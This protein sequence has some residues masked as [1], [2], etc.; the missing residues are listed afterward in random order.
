MNSILLA[1]LLLASPVRA[2][3]PSLALPGGVEP[4]EWEQALRMAGIELA[5]PGELA[6]ITCLPEPGGWMLVAGGAADSR[7]VARVPVPGSQ[8][9]R[10]E[11]ALLAASLMQDLGLWTG[12][13]TTASGPGGDGDAAPQLSPPVDFA[14]EP[15]QESVLQPSSPPPRH[16]TPAP[17]TAEPL[18]G[19]EPLPDTVLTSE[20][21]QI[22]PGPAAEL[23]AEVPPPPPEDTPAEQPA[24]AQSDA[25]APSAAPPEQAI[26]TLW[27][28]TGSGL[29]LRAGLDPGWY[30]ALG[31]G[32]L[33]WDAWWLGLQGGLTSPRALDATERLE[34]VAEWCLGGSLHWSPSQR[35]LAPV[36]GLEIGNAWRRYSMGEAPPVRHTVLLG[37]IEAGLE[38]RRGSWSLA[39]QLGLQIDL[40]RTEIHLGEGEVAPLSRV[41]GEVSVVV[42]RRGEKK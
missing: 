28:S 13:P 11:L 2:V 20:E 18:P 22:E 19:P 30:G 40:D 36:V 33:G 35:R 7:T 10:E 6:S 1:C 23:V 25:P 29:R 38:M 24:E 42:I 9:E 17:V 27:V 12:R 8:Q 16:E 32:L 41:Q 31:L 34:D 3:E 37:G 39:P 21:P 15:A 4:T 5:A 14:P 26:T